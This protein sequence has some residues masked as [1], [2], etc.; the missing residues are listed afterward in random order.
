MQ[1]SWNVM[2]NQLPEQSTR[3]VLWWARNFGR[4]LQATFTTDDTE[5]PDDFNDL[6][7]RADERLKDQCSSP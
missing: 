3:R 5:T 7:A 1:E 2:Y 4:P 6:L